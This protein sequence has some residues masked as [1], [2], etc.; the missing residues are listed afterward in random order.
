[1]DNLPPILPIDGEL[2]LE[3]YTHESLNTK[4]GAI[5]V[6]EH[7]GGAQLATLGDKVLVSAMMNNLFRRRPML[8]ATQLQVSHPSA[9][10]VVSDL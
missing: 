3:V 10:V 1:M 4:R 6:D 9:A 5:T 7:G 2:M 8:S